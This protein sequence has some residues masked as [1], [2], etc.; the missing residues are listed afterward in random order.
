MKFVCGHCKGTVREGNYSKH[1]AS[2]VPH[3]C[4]FE[5][6]FATFIPLPGKPD[7]EPGDIRPI[8]KAEAQGDGHPG[9]E[10]DDAVK[11]VEESG[12][13]EEKKWAKK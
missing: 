13:D 8:E 6:F 7:P 4:G 1:H 10:A 2:F 3:E 11:R 9:E 5:T 12:D